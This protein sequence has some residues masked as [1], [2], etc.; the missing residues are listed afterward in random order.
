ML[1]PESR[2]VPQQAQMF[3]TPFR[4]YG[5]CS[6]GKNDNYLITV[7]TRMQTKCTVEEEERLFKQLNTD[8]VSTKIKESMI[9]L[10]AANL[11]LSQPTNTRTVLTQAFMRENR[12]KLKNRV[13]LKYLF[14]QL[15]CP[16]PRHFSQVLYTSYTY[17][18]FKFQKLCQG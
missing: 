7:I 14:K 16:I 13:E 18:P 6:N 2:A 1:K 5:G 11:E 9:T 3:F 4:A 15:F 17:G 10:A 8:K 12:V